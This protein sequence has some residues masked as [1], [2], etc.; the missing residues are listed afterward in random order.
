MDGSWMPPV[1]GGLAPCVR[2]YHLCRPTDL[3]EWLG[4]EIWIAEGQGRSFINGQYLIFERA[5]VVQR[6]EAWTPAA[7]RT[8][9]VACAERTL[10][11][12]ETARPDT[13]SVAT[14]LNVARSLTPDAE[15]VE[16]VTRSA[17]AM[18]HLARQLDG[19]TRDAVLS[20]YGALAWRNPGMAAWA[21]AGSARSA[22]AAHTW[23]QTMSTGTTQ[24]L[25]PREAERLANAASSAAMQA[26]RSWQT[27]Q[28]M[29]ILQSTS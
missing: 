3:V 23:E 10:G 22:H 21:A 13:P 24:G 27:S 18:W 19:A 6:L 28:L 9:A 1:Y 29:A 26:E 8:F 2:G 7:A 14:A 5:R 4:P 25:H 11:I 12:I 20:I 16:P 17:T 15:K